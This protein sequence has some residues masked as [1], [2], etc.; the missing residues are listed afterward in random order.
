MIT[1]VTQLSNTVSDRA[2]PKFNSLHIADKP[3]QQLSWLS[4]KSVVAV[5]KSF[6]FLLGVFCKLASLLA[7]LC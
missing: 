1:G 4:L 2:N 6:V 7:F 3:V 5:R